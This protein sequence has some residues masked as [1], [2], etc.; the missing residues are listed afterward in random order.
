LYYLG[1]TDDKGPM[2]AVIFAVSELQQEKKLRAN[3]SFL[4]EGEEENGSIGFYD[5]VEQSKVNLLIEV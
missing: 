5:A 2:L 1:A 4:I 3:V